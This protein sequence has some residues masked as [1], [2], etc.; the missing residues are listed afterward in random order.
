MRSQSQVER[1]DTTEGQVDDVRVVGISDV[2]NGAPDRSESTDD[3]VDSLTV[4]G[5]HDIIGDTE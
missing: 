1:N 4:V 3:E 5:V 2:V